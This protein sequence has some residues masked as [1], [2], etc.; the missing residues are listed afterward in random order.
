M[1][2]C[3]RQDTT[4][5]KAAQSGGTTSTAESPI[6]PPTP[7]ISRPVGPVDPSALNQTG[8]V[9]ELDTPEGKLQLEICAPHVV[10]VMV[11]PN[12]SF[13]ARSTLATD[14]KEC[15]TAT[16]WSLTEE[17]TLRTLSTKAL[18]VTV[19]D[20][21]RVAFFD[22]AGSP[23]L[24]E[25]VRAMTPGEVQGESVLTVQQ[26]WNAQDQESLYG[27]GQHQYNLLDIKGYP[28]DLVQYNTQIVVPFFVSSRGYGVLWDN[29]SWT[30]WGDTTDFVSLNKNSGDY[31][32]MFTA[33]K[34]GDYIFRTWASGD[35]QLLIDGQ[36]VVN[37]WRQGWLPGMDLIRVPLNAG[38]KVALDLQFASDIGVSIADLSYKP[39]APSLD[40][41]LWSQVADGIDYTFVYGPDLDDVVGG[42]RRLTGQ[43][44]MMP[45]W[46]LGMWQCRE[47]YASAQEVVDVLKEFRSRAIPLDNIVQDWQFWKPGTWG[48]HE[49]DPAR[50]PDPEAWIASIHD[51][52]HA[53]LMLSVWPK[54]H[55]GTSNFKELEAAGYLY[56]INAREGIK[57]FAGYPMSYYD[58]FNKE[59]RSM[60]WA[61]VKPRLFDV[62]VDAW[63]MDGTEPE[64][65]EGP[66]KSP[67]ERRELYSSHMH[68]TAMGSGS[69][70]LN[71]FS[72]V[73]SQAVYEGQRSASADKRVFILTRS[74]FAG[75]QR[76]AAASWSGD[77]STTWAAFKKQIPA[78]LG[79]SLSGIPYWTTDIGGFAEYP[80]FSAGDPEWEE[81]NA[82]WFQYGTFTPLLRVH[83]QDDRTGPREMW[84][85]KDPIYR[86]HL[87]FDRLRYR[88]FPYIYSL[89]GEVTHGAGTILRPLVMDFREDAASR[90]IRD[91]F[92]FGPGLMV[93]PVT[94]YGAREREVYLPPTTGGWYSLWTGIAVPGEQT[95]MAPAPLDRLPVYVRAGSI[96][97]IGPELEYTGQ[98]PADPLV[99]YVYEGADGSFTLYEDDGLTYNYESGAFSTVQLTYTQASR[100]LSIGARQGSFEG[101]LQQRTFVIVPVSPMAPLA[102]ELDAT[103]NGSAVTYD[104]AAIEVPLP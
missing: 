100:T 23:I 92:L 33:E 60:F 102:L 97:P 42:Y 52:Y 14:V 49:F 104:G 40:T 71:A 15:D 96:L 31:Q 35:L 12:P 20:R 53:R 3:S 57:D 9:P 50:F 75:Q 68:P 98:A 89:A 19:D 88:L 86:I 67:A 81:L 65:V 29:T 1:F 70:M 10:R 55:A 36:S 59:A 5:V 22:A 21:G 28:I 83:G 34:S 66:Y 90:N 103:P 84:N 74:G 80:R 43:A 45:Q 64:V 41:Q 37:H 94:D 79:F 51:D 93:S 99:V 85:F 82:R 7:N 4:G 101:M 46:S 18:Q 63:W 8:P 30:R 17:G 56:D 16:R 87:Y 78:G 95:L 11:S 44:P 73:N 72:L 58:A 25:G 38:Q 61:Q 76:Y 6:E 47:R 24:S 13:F 62:G 77:I 69:R 2:G 32:G 39:P 26:T 54:F 27:L 91:Q 48:S